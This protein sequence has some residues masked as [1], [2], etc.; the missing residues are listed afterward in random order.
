MYVFSNE[1]FRE[2]VGDKTYKQCL[3][4]SK[5]CEGLEVVFREG[6]KRGVVRKEQW[7]AEKDWCIEVPD[8]PKEK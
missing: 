7:F 2:A 6:S 3:C 1:K 8:K 5:K 4:W